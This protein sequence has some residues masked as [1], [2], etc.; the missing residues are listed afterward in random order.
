MH[1]HLKLLI[2]KF[3]LIFLQLFSLI[4]NYHLNKLNYISSV[5]VHFL[6]FLFR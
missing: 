4:I 2:R 3:L 5:F 6:K 1:T